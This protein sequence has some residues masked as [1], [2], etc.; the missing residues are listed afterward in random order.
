[1]PAPT[2]TIG[3]APASRAKPQAS[4]DATAPMRANGKAAAHATLPKT[5]RNGSWTMDARGIQ[6]ALEGMG[7]TG[8]AGSLPPTSAK[9]QMKST[10]NPCPA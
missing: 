4:G 8:S 3:R 6:C 7:R 10:L 2:A 5:D 9:I 1:M